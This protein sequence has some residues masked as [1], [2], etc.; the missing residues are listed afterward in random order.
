LLS[1][2]FNSGKN[3]FMKKNEGPSGTPEFR[4]ISL[5]TQLEAIR[6][7]D[8]IIIGGGATG[9]GVA[10]D[11]ISRGYRTL[12]LE[13][14]D[15]A[16]GTSSRSTKLV[17]GGVRYLAQGDISLVKEALHER[18][19]LLKNAAHLVKN[20][21]FIIP[22][23]EWWGGIF[24]TIGLKV[25][26]FLSGR[27]S[28]GPS[29]HLSKKETLK[30]ISTIKSKGLKGGVLYQHGDKIIN[31][32]KVDKLIKKEEK[33]KGVSATDIETG[34][35]YDLTAKT[36]INA[37]GIFVDE[38]IKMDLPETKNMVRPSQGAHIVLDK[39]FL[40]GDHAI[41]IPKTDDG[42]VLFAVPWHNKVLVGTTDTPLDEHSLEPRILEDEVD[43]ILNTAGRYLARAPQ[44]SDALAVFAGLRPLAAANDSSG[45]TKE[46]SRSHKIVV[47]PAG[48]ITI[49]GG[50]WTTFRK[51]G[52]DTIDK[53][54]SSQYLRSR[55]SGSANMTI[56][57]SL[58]APNFNDPLYVYGT[59]KKYLLDLI[60][61]APGLVA[62]L[63]DAL[64]YNEAQ[65]V[66]A[67][68]NEMARTVEDVIARRTRALFL[69]A[70]AALRMAP[71]VAA[72]VAAELGKDEL[73]EKEQIIA[74]N[75]IA[76]NY[77]I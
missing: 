29:V 66:W 61:A 37:T 70:R 31:Y 3:L 21:S 8:V 26:D 77:L 40:P 49:I 1:F 19:L 17:H 30:R 60:E 33:I 15:F 24:Y 47:S 32:F 63:D 39:S 25:Y 44:R 23:Y 65:V 50:K 14:A 35:S 7:W 75:K 57:G 69:D 59:D 36:V 12:L 16:K 13:Q 20:Q 9:L 43:F 18:G 51:M 34:K 68:R 72:L 10:L 48:L 55:A 46:I 71:R 54:I 4:R 58:Y 41:M 62:K 2:A 73:W 38:I 27:L 74:F 52:E 22:N 53:A 67:V 64:D 45:K 5:L 76:S 28:L 11:S 42:R 56:H 6:E